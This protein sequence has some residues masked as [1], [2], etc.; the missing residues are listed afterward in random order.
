MGGSL[1]YLV[2]VKLM[3]KWA[4]FILMITGVDY[5]DF[6]RMNRFTVILRLFFSKNKANT[7][8]GHKELEGYSQ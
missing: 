3:I 5:R 2:L 1:T 8:S 6:I 4:I 7:S